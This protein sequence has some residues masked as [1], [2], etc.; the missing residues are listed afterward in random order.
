MDK[1]L[2]DVIAEIPPHALGKTLAARGAYLRSVSMTEMEKADRTELRVALQGLVD[3]A[4]LELERLGMGWEDVESG[5]RAV[6]NCFELSL[7][8]QYLLE[9][10]EN[11]KNW[12]S[13]RTHEE[14]DI[15][16]SMLRV[17]GE[18]SD[19]VAREKVQAWVRALQ[20][21]NAKHQMPKATR[22]PRWSEL[23]KRYGLRDEYDAL[24]GLYSKY[25]HPCAWLTI[26]PN[27]EWAS[28]FTNTFA[29]YAQMYA[30]DVARRSLRAVKLDDAILARGAF[31]SNEC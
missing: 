22:L 10:P 20:A 9:S 13:L 12:L 23:A 19:P 3:R 18:D 11:V 7:I 16:E 6:R 26:K 1:R 2:R 15:F 5:A 4:G 17:F 27:H 31:G 28:T 14:I 25:I 30:V 21:H 24:Y 8:V 29:I